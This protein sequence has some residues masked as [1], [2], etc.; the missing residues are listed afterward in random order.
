MCKFDDLLQKNPYFKFPNT[1]FRLQEVIV[2]NEYNM[3]NLHISYTTN[4][5]D[6][7]RLQAFECWLI[8]QIKHWGKYQHFYMHVHTVSFR[9]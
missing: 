5:S 8:T 4:I 2:Y 9:I 3:S 7:Y 6:L 1:S